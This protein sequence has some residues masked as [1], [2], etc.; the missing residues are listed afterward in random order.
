MPQVWGEGRFLVANP[1]PCAGTTGSEQI[2]EPGAPHLSLPTKLRLALC[3]E[4]VSQPQV[5]Q[6][7]GSVRPSPNTSAYRAVSSSGNSSSLPGEIK[8]FEYLAIKLRA[9][10]VLPQLKTETSRPCSS[11]RA[12]RKDQLS[13][14]ALSVSSPGSAIPE[15]CLSRTCS[16]LH[17]TGKMHWLH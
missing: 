6:D 1:S 11:V 8:P 7:K 5:F 4:W 15:P 10:R 9:N 2:A 17:G 12:A 14:P 13:V 3:R 16:L